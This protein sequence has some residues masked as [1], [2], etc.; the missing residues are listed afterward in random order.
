MKSAILYRGPSLIDGSPIVAIATGLDAKSA[1]PKTGAMVQTWILRDDM[2]PVEAIHNGADAAICGGCQHRERK[3]DNGKVKRTCYVRVHNAPGSVYRAMLRGSYPTVAID[4]MPTL[5]RN[6]AI[7]LGS[8]GDPAAVPLDVW[9]AFLSESAT[10]TGYT[11]QWRS[12]RVRS[13][14]KFLM[15]SA[16]IPADVDRAARF[17]FR[18]FLVTPTAAELRKMSDA[19]RGIWESV[20]T[21][22]VCPASKEAGKVATCAD[23]NA[24]SGS[25]ETPSIRIVKH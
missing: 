17:G 6:R 19:L 8:Y 20:G 11:H 14:S 10:H 3:H 5:G 15:A 2:H 18:S 23:C 24:C 4:D 7:R 13:Y 25:G 22:T 1:N 16:D 12:A 9:E 21:L